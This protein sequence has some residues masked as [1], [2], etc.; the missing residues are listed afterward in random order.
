VIRRAL[1]GLPETLDG[2]YER[3]LLGIEKEKQEFAHRIFQCLTVSVRP[4]RVDELSEILA[5]RFDAGQHPQYDTDW[6]LEDA[7]EAVLSVCSSLI[8][9][10][11][12][13]GS[14]VVQFSHFSVKE[15]LT[16]DRLANAAEHL[17]RFHVLPQL[18]HI[19]LAQASLSVL[20]HLG[21][22][23]DKASIGTFPFACYAA[24]Y[25][26]DHAR[27]E[28]VSS[29][30]IQDAMEQLFDE[31]G[32][33]FATWIWIHDVDHPFRPHTLEAH[34]PE[35]EA[36]PLYYAALCGFHGLVEHLIAIHPEAI[37]FGGGNHGSAVNVALVKGHVDIAMLLLEHGADVNTV[38]SR[39]LTPL[40]QA[41][42][43][44][45][46]DHFKLLLEHHA[47]I[48]LRDTNG[49][50]PL[51]QAATFG[52]LAFTRELLRRGAAVDALNH[53]GW[54]PLMAASRYG[55]LDVARCL[56]ESGACVDTPSGAGWSPLKM[57][58]RYGHLDIVRFL[59]ETGAAVDTTVVS[60]TTGTSRY[61][62]LPG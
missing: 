17:S 51:C 44:D 19:I 13:E 11:E 50:T 39:G 61:R 41:I 36:V 38:D 4:L 57:A 18:A 37:N 49:V 21:G 3:T 53:E 25:W 46:S 26:V 56:V 58:S 35:P 24:Q 59:V 54:S 31:E 20:L 15:F 28:N 34:P 40:H 43:R 12:V 9:V 27:F 2:T 55:R 33:S 16:S 30:S 60:I 5:I 32:P 7:Q 6:R 62:P 48:H 10:V 1:D 23:V 29:S 22:R 14:P 45:R 8:M 47:D 52:E 42:E